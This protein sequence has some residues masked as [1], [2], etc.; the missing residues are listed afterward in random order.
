MLRRSH[1]TQ[2]IDSGILQIDIPP[3]L[4]Q[5]TVFYVQ[6]CR[7]I[8]LSPPCSGYFPAILRSHVYRHYGLLL[9]AP[10]CSPRSGVTF[11][12]SSSP[13]G[14]VG[15]H[16]SKGLIEE[17]QNT[18]IRALVQQDI[19]S[20]RYVYLQDDT[21]SVIYGSISMFVSGTTVLPAISPFIRLVAGLGL[22]HSSSVHSF[23]S[24]S[25]RRSR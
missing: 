4:K 14:Y 20:G 11:R 9:P 17:I 6:P 2:A 24:A 1:Y 8:T 3:V 18:S 19:K 7:S 22:K 12:R 13:C 25:P 5:N 10:I 15:I 16:R 21:H 23:A